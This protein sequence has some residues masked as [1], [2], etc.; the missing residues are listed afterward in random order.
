MENPW[1]NLDPNNS[2]DK[3]WLYTSITDTKSAS[4][5]KFETDII[6]YLIIQEHNSEK[7]FY[8]IS[9]WF[10]D[11]PNRYIAIKNEFDYKFDKKLSDMNEG[12]MV[13]IY[14]SSFKVYNCKFS[15]P[16]NFDFL[17]ILVK[18]DE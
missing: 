12:D 7:V 17:K 13:N 5:D 1:F 10:K 14:S 9:V 18:I 11:D 2:K 15:L 8:R 4:I 16:K 3:W 6:C